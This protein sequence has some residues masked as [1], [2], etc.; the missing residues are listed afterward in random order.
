MKTINIK[1][2]AYTSVA[3]LLLAACTSDELTDGTVQDLPEGKYP[4]QITDVSL[5]A[6]SSAE[7]WERMLRK[8][9]CRKIQPMVTTV[10]G[11]TETS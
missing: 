1:Q 3:A 9:V 10:C 4:L 5:T 8:H 7:P 6:G 2:L 11:Q